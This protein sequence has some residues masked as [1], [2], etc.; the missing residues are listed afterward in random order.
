M[1]SPSLESFGRAKRHLGSQLSA[2]HL[3]SP[4]FPT[5]FPPGL[6][7]QPCLPAL[8]LPEAS[9][10]LTCSSAPCLPACS[11][12][13]SPAAPSLFSPAGSPVF[14]PVSYQCSLLSPSLPVL[15]SAPSTLSTCILVVPPLAQHPHLSLP[16]SYLNSTH[17]FSPCFSTLSLFCRCVCSAS[18]LGPHPHPSLDLS[19]GFLPTLLLTLS[20]TFPFLGAFSPA[21]LPVL[22]QHLRPTGLLHLSPPSSPAPCSPGCSAASFV[23]A[24]HL[25]LALAPFPVSLAS[26]VPCSGLPH[27]LGPHLV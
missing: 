26:H 22:H 15:S 27:P 8:H 7:L 21:A 10:H 11:P 6:H 24:L 12:P 9:P 1:V 2:A 4:L 18:P 23:S 16:V 20:F 3:K 19:S 14:S 25:Q 13:S 5:S 17:L